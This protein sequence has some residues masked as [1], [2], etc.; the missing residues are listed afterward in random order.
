[1]LNKLIAIKIK[2]R[3]KLIQKAIENPIDFQDKIL[4]N[5]IQLSK[6]TIFGKKH[7]FSNIKTYSQFTQKIP[8]QN[9]NSLKTYIDMARMGQTNIL[10]PGK[11]K[12]FAKS[13]GTTKNKSKFIPITTESLKKCHFQA[14]R[15]ML[16]IYL[17]YY[18]NS[19]ILTG[20]SLMIGGST[21]IHKNNNYYTGDLSA[22]IIQNL[23]RWVQLK[24]VP[25]IKT[26][27]IE[28]WEQKIQ[29]IIQES[30]NKN[31]TS[32][33]GVPSWTMMILDQLMKKRNN[34]CLSEIWP[35][36]ELYMHGG[37]S[38]EPY[39]NQ[40]ADFINSKKLNY[41]EIYN[42][43]EGFF[44]IQNDF[45]KND[46]LL[47]INHGIFYEFS[48]IRTNH[49]NSRTKTII[50][51][52]EVELNKTYAM[53]ITTNGGLWRYKIGDTVTFTSLKPYKIQISGRTQS[54]INAFG[55]EL[56]EN[57]ANTAINYACMQTNAIIQDY[58]AGPYFY[59]DKSGAHEW[60]IEFKKTPKNLA[61]FH[62]IMD[63]KLQELNCDYESKRKKSILL[64]KPII[65]VLQKNFF[66][67][68]LKKQNKIG[69]QNKIQ[70]L[71]NNR[72]FITQLIKKA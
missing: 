62:E 40:F 45:E 4:I 39:K 53:I 58:I 28:N 8:V 6:K 36:L 47:L 56:Q 65:H 25:S 19:Q 43:S 55:E 68:M 30:T 61:Q 37:I 52:K 48:P 13:S 29:Q 66:Y 22:I 14:G 17:N 50:P 51:L 27:L 64:R 31:I 69:G 32:I 16:S 11:I 23:P 35:N 44:G 41:L 20:K 10:W 3:I 70:R 18:P 12:W 26:A 7:D 42:A 15:D 46:L 54:F 60:F 33:S 57:H 5:N 49:D 59:N 9:Y 2:N 67:Q 21:S 1:M 24:R 38:F 72:N 63:K 34:Q 71:H